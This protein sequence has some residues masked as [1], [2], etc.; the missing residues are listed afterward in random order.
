[1]GVFDLHLCKTKGFGRVM[2]LP[3]RKCDGWGELNCTL[4]T[5]RDLSELQNIFADHW[6][7]DTASSGIRL[8]GVGFLWIGE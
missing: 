1:M 6:E 4:D 7:S 2:T 3:Y 5:A 8:P